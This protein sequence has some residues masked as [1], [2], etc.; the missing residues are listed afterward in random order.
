[1]WGSRREIVNDKV[2]RGDGHNHKRI[3]ILALEWRI[4]FRIALLLLLLL[5]WWWRV[6]AWSLPFRIF[7]IV[8]RITF[9]QILW[10]RQNGAIN[11]SFNPNLVS[12][13][14]D[15][16]H[17]K[18]S[19]ELTP[20]NFGSDWNAHYR[21]FPNLDWGVEDVRGRRSERWQWRET[22]TNSHQQIST[23]TILVAWNSITLSLY[24]LPFFPI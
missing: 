2:A 11:V 17:G 15:S 16:D 23:K 5:L 4:Q 7:T 19:L 12:S 14:S 8:C 10:H 20:S 18:H 13:C 9:D 3:Y 22:H 24:S 21:Q 1:M 6:A